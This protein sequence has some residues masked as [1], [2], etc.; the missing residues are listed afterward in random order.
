MK[1]NVLYFLI[2]IILPSCFI[3][4]NPITDKTINKKL[5]TET[6]NI[7]VVTIVEKYSRSKKWFYGTIEIYNQTPL[8]CEFNFNQRLKTNN[9]EISPTWNIF[10][11][12]YGPESFKIK[13]NSNRK[14]IVVWPVN[15][16]EID[17]KDISIIPDTQ[18]NGGDIPKNQLNHFIDT[19][20]VILKYEKLINIDTTKGNLRYGKTK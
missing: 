13:P 17:F 15:R 8:T 19:S 1:R 20:K 10:P 12:S 2:I 16:K 5:I 7:K 18:I 9:K 6:N 11:I 14:W 3:T 4:S